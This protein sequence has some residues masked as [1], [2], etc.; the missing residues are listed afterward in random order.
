[1]KSPVLHCFMPGRVLLE[2]HL[3]G[4][5]INYCISHHYEGSLQQL[6][7]T[8]AR[9]EAEFH[10]SALLHLWKHALEDFTEEH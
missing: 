3:R 8:A 9:A 5:C 1:M 7:N 10:V 4:Y 6:F 2:A